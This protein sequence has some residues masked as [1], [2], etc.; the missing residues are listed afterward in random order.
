MINTSSQLTLPNLEKTLSLRSSTNLNQQNSV[1]PTIFQNDLKKEIEHQQSQLSQ[2][3]SQIQDEKE[4]EVSLKQ[5]IRQKRICLYSNQNAWQ[6][7]LKDP[8]S[9]TDKQH[10]CVNEIIKELE[11]FK[12]QIEIVKKDIIKKIS[13]KLIGFEFQKDQVVLSNVG[14][15]NNLLYFILEGQVSIYESSSDYGE[16]SKAQ[17]I[18]QYQRGQ[19]INLNHIIF[20]RPFADVAICD[21]HTLIAKLDKRIFRKYLQ[22]IEEEM[23]DDEISFLQSIDLFSQLNI[24]Q[25]QDLL[26]NIDIKTLELN[27]TLYNSYSQPE[28]FYIIKSGK[29]GIFRGKQVDKICKQSK[30]QTFIDK[31]E[32]QYFKIMNLSNKEESSQTK[33]LINLQKTIQNE[34]PFSQIPCKSAYVKIQELNTFDFLGYEEILSKT[35]RDHDAKSLQDNTV[36]YVFRRSY[37]IKKLLKFKCFKKIILQKRFTNKLENKNQYNLSIQFEQDMQLGLKFIEN[38]SNQKNYL[39]QDLYLNN[40]VFSDVTN[41]FDTNQK[42]FYHD[43]NVSKQ[44][45]S[46]SLFSSQ[47]QKDFDSPQK[48]CKPIQPSLNRLANA[49]NKKLLVEQSYHLENQSNKDAKNNLQINRFIMR[50]QDKIDANIQKQKQQQNLSSLN[51]PT[52]RSDYSLKSARKLLNHNQVNYNDYKNQQNTQHQKIFAKTEE[53]QAKQNKYQNKYNLQQNQFNQWDSPQIYPSPLNSISMNFLKTEQEYLSGNLQQKVKSEQSFLYYGQQRNY[54][55]VLSSTKKVNPHTT[56]KNIFNDTSMNLQQRFLKNKTNIKQ[57]KKGSFEHL[58]M[59]SSQNNLKQSFSQNKKQN[60]NIL[61]LEK[62][63]NV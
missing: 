50:Q 48:I 46:Y 43:N 16:Q 8:Q 54:N 5:Q 62:I 20:Q 33:N 49:C 19:C 58:Q 52:S 24:D 42:N 18:R 38:H 28:E 22:Q 26:L 47:N 2:E 1:S 4:I 6:I 12:H 31:E 55:S 45:Q 13:A 51:I 10:D 11:I 15:D 57:K 23:L 34:D 21:S 27:Q 29:I 3:I 17:F 59:I 25:L 36:L 9:R 63:S 30:Q 60:F 44:K 14:L 32:K 56:S 39:L 35:N 41:V 37:F 7:L 40:S 61:S 53:S